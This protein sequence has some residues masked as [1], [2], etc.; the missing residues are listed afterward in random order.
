MTRLV[1]S[2]LLG[3]AIAL[4]I[5]SAFVGCHSTARS[6]A[7]QPGASDELWQA[8]LPELA[9]GHSDKIQLA[10]YAGSFLRHLDPPVKEFT[11]RMGSEQ[12]RLE[13]RLEALARARHI[14]LKFHYA[15]DVTGRAR[16][17][18]EKADGDALQADGNADFQRDMLMFMYA[19][20]DWQRHLI[21]AL[22]PQA[23]NDSD[24]K[25]YL[26]ESLAAHEAHF[27]EIQRLLQRYKWQ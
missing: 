1:R 21:A 15:A 11:A 24:L 6:P 2:L 22:I 25:S 18:M 7:T 26:E 16:E 10:W 23:G 17:A 13:Q 5:G 14:S 9:K 27:K 4:S 3:T 19:D 20:Y 8:V 12:K